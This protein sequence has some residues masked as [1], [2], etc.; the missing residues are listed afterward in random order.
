MSIKITQLPNFQELTTSQTSVIVGGTEI[1]SISLSPVA[2]SFLSGQFVSST[3]TA[4]YKVFYDNG[5]LSD[6]LDVAETVP[7]LTPN[8]KVLGAFSK[9]GIFF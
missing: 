4:T 3:S 7:T 9:N 1:V 5:K 8:G 2:A 6:S